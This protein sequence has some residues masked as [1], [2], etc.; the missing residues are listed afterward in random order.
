[1]SRRDLKSIRQTDPSDPISVNLTR[2]YDMLYTKGDIWVPSPPPKDVLCL[3]DN[4]VL[5]VKL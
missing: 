1:M 5:L 3:E 4:A 2:G